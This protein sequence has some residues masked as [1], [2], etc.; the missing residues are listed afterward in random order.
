MR[1]GAYHI[2]EHSESL[3]MD[4]QGKFIVERFGIEDAPVREILT[5]GEAMV[6]LHKWVPSWSWPEVMKE[7]E[8]WLEDEKKKKSEI[9]KQSG[10]LRI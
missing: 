8:R 2:H 7:A 6:W 10:S 1:D 3:W 5:E 4:A 9:L